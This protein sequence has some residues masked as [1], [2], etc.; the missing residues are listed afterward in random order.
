MIN[1]RKRRSAELPKERYEVLKNI[2]LAG[3]LTPPTKDSKS[4]IESKFTKENAIMVS[5]F[6]GKHNPY[7]ME[8]VKILFQV[9]EKFIY[10]FENSTKAVR[11]LYNLIRFVWKRT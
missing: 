1:D 7:S 10:P 6:I 2:I 9:S 8:M 11:F 3:I 5:Q 4:S